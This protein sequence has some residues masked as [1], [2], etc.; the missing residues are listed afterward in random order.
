MVLRTIYYRQGI[1]LDES[2]DL[3]I[4]D[5]LL[6][7]FPP[8]CFSLNYIFPLTMQQ[9]FFWSW[10]KG[11]LDTH[12]S[13]LTNKTKGTKHSVCNW[14]KSSQSS[15]PTLCL[16]LLCLC[17]FVHI[18]IKHIDFLLGR[19]L[20]DFKWHLFIGRSYDSL[21]NQREWEF[22]TWLSMTSV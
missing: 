14:S 4:V 21:A 11:K 3:L 20:D 2:E 5:I 6:S 22:G 10:L 16:S 19:F 8:S 12:F 18:K 13:M 9:I 15:S 7:C 1:F 17:H